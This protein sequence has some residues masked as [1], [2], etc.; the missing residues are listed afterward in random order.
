[1]L[2]EL[3]KQTRQYQPT[4]D[5]QMGGRFSNHL[6]MALIALE[7]M[8]ASDEQLQNFYN[9]HNKH[10]EKHI[11][12]GLRIN[13]E[14]FNQHIGDHDSSYAYLLFFENEINNNSIET[15]LATYLPMLSS[16]IAAHLLHG[17]IRS[18]YGYEAQ[19]TSEVAAGLAYLA[20]HYLPIEKIKGE[21]TSNQV[22][23]VLNNI[24][25]NKQLQAVTFSSGSFPQAFAKLAKLSAFNEMIATLK[26][27][28]SSV[29][30]LAE[31]A[32]KLLQEGDDLISLHLVTSTQALR[33]LLPLLKKEDQ[34]KLIRYYWQAFAAIYIKLGMPEINS[35]DKSNASELSWDEIKKLACQNSDA[36]VIK[37]T[38]S[39]FLH[40]QTYSDERFKD[41][42]AA[43]FD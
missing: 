22:N 23:E 2:N 28:N 18:A 12:N 21:A 37:L 14:N 36:H 3:L 31:T 5:N 8:G 10:L 7:R 38:Y 16:G 25:N 17:L 33:T 13:K 20:S 27:D 43:Q 42:A 34:E 41:V 19:S 15:V 40:A 4:F 29:Q 26:I 11:D 6:P 32:L 24:H 1:M 39:C 9:G 30:Q 35:D